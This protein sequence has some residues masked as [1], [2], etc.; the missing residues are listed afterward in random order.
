M[1]LLV[2]SGI[3]NRGMFMIFEID[4][5]WMDIVEDVD[6]FCCE[7]IGAYIFALTALFGIFYMFFCRFSIRDG[8]CGVD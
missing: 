7:N 3:W 1:R 4:V 2:V 6:E 5:S 8:P